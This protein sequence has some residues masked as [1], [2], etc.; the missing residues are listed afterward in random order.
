MSSRVFITLNQDVIT[1][2]VRK[3]ERRVCYAAP[4]IYDWVAEALIGVSQSLARENVSVVI[5]PDPFVMQVGYGT[6]QA[7][8]RLHD[9]EIPVRVQKGLRIGVV[10]A[11]DF[12]AVFAPP[13]LNVDV[14]P[15]AGI[16]N[17]VRLGAQEAVRL[18]RAVAGDGRAD[19]P[20]ERP[21]N[22]AVVNNEHENIAPSISIIGDALLQESDLA[23]I[24][25][26]LV[27]HPPVSPDLDRQMRIINSVFQV[28]K[29][30]LNGAKLSQRR[31]PLRAEELGI[32]DVEMRRRIGASFKLFEGEVDSFTRAF[33]DDLD[34]IKR[35]YGLKAVG[36][37]GYLILT[38]DCAGLENALRWF[39]KN[40]KI[41]QQQLEEEI[42]KE[43]DHSKDRLKELFASNLRRSGEDEARL[44]RRLES[45]LY[46]MRIPNANDVLSNLGCEWYIF[47]LSEQMMD[48]G[49]FAEKV[50]VLYGRPIEE[51]TRV[52]SAVGVRSTH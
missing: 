32:E 36:E 40:L 49:D 31:L 47:N 11:D 18:L 23:Q 52:E 45:V 29:V 4:G 15:N 38:R 9:N 44:S 37:I 2:L 3:A 12:A 28:V 39:Q 21:E 20:T 24:H 22:L 5:D 6:E 7:L 25:E 51:L 14:F 34:E 27:R 19:G 26:T 33:Q 8:R 35:K 16:P 17:A 10:I 48:R 1:E 42:Q 30:T 43:L 46:K 13:A 50:K 41:A